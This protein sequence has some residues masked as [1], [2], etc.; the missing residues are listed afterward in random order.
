MGTGVEVAA[1]GDEFGVGGG[2]HLA[3]FIPLDRARF[4]RRVQGVRDKQWFFRRFAA[5]K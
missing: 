4:A 2:T 1:T 3:A 5:E